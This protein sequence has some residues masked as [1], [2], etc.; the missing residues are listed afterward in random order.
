MVSKSLIRLPS[1][2]LCHQCQR[3]FPR[4]QQSHQFSSS[5]PAAADRFNTF[6]ESLRRGGLVGQALSTPKSQEQS[7]REIQQ[8]KQR[9]EAQA[10]RER[11]NLLGGRHT[12]K[13][14]TEAKVVADAG[15]ANRPSTAEA[16]GELHHLH[17]YATKHNTHVTLTRPN[18]EPMLSLSTGNI[19]FRKSHRGTFD[20]AYQLV[21]YSIAQMIEKG[22]V[23]K[24]QQ[25]EIIMRGYGPGREAFQ[26]V[27]LG[28]EGRLIKPKVYRVTDSTRLKF[29]GTRSPAVRRL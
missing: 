10:K 3:L 2:S 28:M 21:T 8:Q 24:I 7:L 16:F 11:F 20:A 14:L 22:F 12:S 9:E 23:Q 5:S 18:R 25:L 17:V 13:A 6:A 19:N 26:K 4:Q 15:M 27:L 29:G 1:P